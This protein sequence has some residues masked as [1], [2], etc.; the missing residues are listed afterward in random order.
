[1]ADLTLDLAENYAPQTERPLGSYLGLAGTFTVLL[2]TLLVA[3]ERSNRLPDRVRIADVAL[4]GVATH[5]LSR[6]LT[7]DQESA[8]H[9]E[10]EEQPQGHGLRLAVGEL[11]VCPYCLGLWV[12]GGFTAGLVLAPRSTRLVASVFAV[13]AVSDFLQV[14]Y[15]TAEER[16]EPA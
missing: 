16:S 4:L 1:M 9:G 7:K 13:K 11:L 14:A 8:G 3:A 15:K 2:G 10:G 5:K 6:L 12:A